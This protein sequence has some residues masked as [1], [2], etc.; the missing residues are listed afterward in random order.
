MTVSGIEQWSVYILRCKDLSLYTGVAK[1]VAKRF[2]EHQ[3]QGPKCAKYLKGRG[4]LILVYCEMVGDKSQALKREYALKQLSKTAK[5][6]LV[7]NWLGSYSLL[8]ILP[9]TK[10]GS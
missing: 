2:A 8:N 3:S 4:P 5:E 9:G 1:D 7:A 10:K 6:T